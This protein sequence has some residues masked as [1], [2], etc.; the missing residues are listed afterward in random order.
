VFFDGF[1]AFWFGEPK[2]PALQRTVPRFPRSIFRMR[3]N[4]TSARIT[5]SESFEVLKTEEGQLNAVFACFGS[6]AQHAQMFEEALGNFLLAYN[7][8]RVVKLTSE[9]LEE[10]TQSIHG[11]T[12]GQLLHELKSRVT[13]NEGD[14]RERMEVAL[15]VRN[16][17]M[18]RWFLDRKDNFKDEAGRMALLQELAGMERLLDSARIMANAMRIAMCEKLAI[19]DSWLPKEASG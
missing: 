16:Y 10:L 6:A 18:H 5:M 9:E 11:R 15:K 1:T 7:H 14:T 13:F 19:D 4:S 8:I 17:L 3:S 12:M 2:L